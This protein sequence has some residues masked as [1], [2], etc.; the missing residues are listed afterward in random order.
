MK[1][2]VLLIGSGGREH[3]LAWKLA[4][5]PLLGNLYCA[6]GNAG[7]SQVCDC[8]EMDIERHENI[9][10]FCQDNEIDL[11]VVGPEAPLVAGL[12]D[13]LTTQGIKAFGP[14]AAAARLEGS[15]AFTHEICDQFNIPA[16]KYSTFNK[17]P[18][19]KSYARQHAVPMVIKADGLAA[20]K[21]VVIAQSIAQACD[22]IDA[23]FEGE[24]G[25]AGTNVVIE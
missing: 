3:A 18:K 7:I 16:A 24:F 2:N 22:A 1:M 12:V 19:A 23:C 13:E 9:V 14:T 11:V 6:P 17:A 4:R 8:V 21:G 25:D 15:K 5:S 10:S 20:G